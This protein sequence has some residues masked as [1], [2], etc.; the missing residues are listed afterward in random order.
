MSTAC[1]KNQQT[2]DQHLPPKRTAQ[3]VTN[4]SIM[5]LVTFLL[6]IC[7]WFEDFNHLVTCV[8]WAK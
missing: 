4:Q 1:K 2:N 8:L 3:T 5:F 6:F 7:L